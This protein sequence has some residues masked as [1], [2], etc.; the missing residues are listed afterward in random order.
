L[1][2]AGPWQPAQT[3]SAF[4]FPAPSSKASAEAQI[5]DLSKD[6]PIFAEDELPTDKRL[7][8]VALAQASEPLSLRTAN[9]PQV[10]PLRGT[11][12]PSGLARQRVVAEGCD[13]NGDGAGPRIP[14]RGG[15][16]QS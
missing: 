12:L 3:C 4:F 13:A 7:D 6:Y 1:F 10:R 11:R 16:S 8:K 5:K 15:H 14:P 2:P 9:V